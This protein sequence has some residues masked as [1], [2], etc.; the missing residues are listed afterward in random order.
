MLN[1]LEVSE[2]N[3]MIEE[4]NLDVRTITLG[5]SLLD[6]IDSDLKSHA[7]NILSQLGITPTGAIQMLYSQVILNNGMPFDLKLPVQKPVAAGS[8]TREELD[9]EL[10][11][12][13]ASLQ[14]SKGYTAD[15]VDM[16]LS[17]KFGI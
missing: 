2:T 9:L 3:K 10:S 8:L 16:K 17:R 12:G 13:I 7:E 6:C 5:I 14:E 4:E 1:I 11:K 15:E